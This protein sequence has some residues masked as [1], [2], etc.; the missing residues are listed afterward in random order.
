MFATYTFKKRWI[1][2]TYSTGNMI[3]PTTDRQSNVK[4]SDS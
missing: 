2:H 1:V 4:V 3:D